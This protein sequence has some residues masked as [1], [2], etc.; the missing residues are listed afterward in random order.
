MNIVEIASGSPDLQILV[1]ALGAA[2]LV[3]TIQDSNDIT[4]FAPTD[5][6]FGQLAADLGFTGDMTDEDAVFD[7]LVAALTDLSDT[8]DP[9]LPLTQILTYHVASGVLDAAAVAS[10]PSIPTL[11]S[12]VITPAVPV[13]EDLEPDILNPS[14]IDTDILADNGIVHVIDRVLLPFDLPNN[15]VPS[16]TSIVAASGELDENPADFDI[17][18][19]AVQTAG[20]AGVLDTEGLDATVFAPNDGAFLSLAQSLGFSGTDEAGAL[21]FIVA[22]LTDLGGGDPIPLL[23]EILTYHVSPEAKQSSAVLAATEFDTLQGGTITR[24]GTTLVDNE[25]DLPDPGLITS[26]LDILASNGIVHA[27]DQVLLPI[28]IPASSGAGQPLV[29]IGSPERDLLAGGV[30]NDVLIGKG[31]GDIKIGGG[32]ADVFALGADGARDKVIDF[33]IGIDRLDVSDWG[34][35]AIGELF[36][37]QRGDNSVLVFNHDNSAV[38]QVATGTIATTDLTEDSFIFAL[39]SAPE[40]ITGTDARDQLQGT[41]DADVLD[42][43]LSRDFYTGGTGADIFVAG[44]DVA[45]VVLDFIEGVDQLD[46]TAWGVAATSDLSFQQLKAGIIEISAAGNSVLVRAADRQISEADFSDSDFLI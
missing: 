28:D 8:G 31:G 36:L 39:S 13:L 7:F 2:D 42:G 11:Q 22:A 3:T 34:V 38:V 17:L 15:D 37:K 6:A 10:A 4:V 35:T 14:L 44:T 25:P 29:L 45:D 43:G 46:L 33:E 20:L 19:T 26:Q 30:D 16:I 18:L 41:E 1:R 21:N 27:I 24:S 40:T 23:T 5:A 32:G 12:G 9:V